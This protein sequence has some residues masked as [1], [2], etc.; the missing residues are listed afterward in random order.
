MSERDS[1]K[2]TTPV[3]TKL[4]SNNDSGTTPTRT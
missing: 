3:S 4:S 2:R 1:W